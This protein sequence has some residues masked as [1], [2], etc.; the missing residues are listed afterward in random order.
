[1]HRLSFGLLFVLVACKSSGGEPIDPLAQEYCAVPCSTLGS[2]ERVVN[3]ALKTACPEE[4]RLYYRCVT[5]SATDGGCDESRCTAEW[6]ARE[7]CMAPPDAGTGGGGGNGGGGG[8]G[9]A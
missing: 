4:T 8:G 2:C 5:D 9:G 7:A 6:A 3:E 1:M